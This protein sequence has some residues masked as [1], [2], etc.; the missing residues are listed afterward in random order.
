MLNPDGVIIGNYRC[1]LAASDLNRQ[2]SD[3]KIGLFPEIFFMKG[4]LKKTKDNREIELFCDF[5]GHSRKANMFLYGC[6]DKIAEPSRAEQLFPL[7]K[8]NIV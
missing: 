6:E 7:Y 4:V 1:S 8:L 2:W 5:H 3:T